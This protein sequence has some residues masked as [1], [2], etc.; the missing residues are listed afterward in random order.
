MNLFIIALIIVSDMQSQTH[1]TLTRIRAQTFR[2]R[3]RSFTLYKY[4]YMCFPSTTCLRF[5]HPKTATSQCSS[6][7]DAAQSL[8]IYIYVTENSTLYIRLCYKRRTAFVIHA[9]S[10]LGY[11]FRELSDS[12]RKSCKSL[13]CKD[14]RHSNTTQR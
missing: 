12:S 6:F 10:S 2:A 5:I 1:S 11:V 3:Q 7:L 8:Y 14:K 9:R 4:I 13:E